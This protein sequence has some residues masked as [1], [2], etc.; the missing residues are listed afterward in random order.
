MSKDE[1]LKK[2]WNPIKRRIN[3][4]YTNKEKMLKYYPEIKKCLDLL[5]KEYFWCEEENYREIIFNIINDIKDEPKCQYCNNK[6]IFNGKYTNYC[7]EHNRVETNKKTIERCKG[8]KQ[9][10][11]TIEKRANSNRGQKR[12]EQARYNISLGQKNSPNYEIKCK[13]MKEIGSKPE[14]RK[15]RSERM[16]KAIEEGRFT[17][18]ITNTRTHFTTEINGK[19]FRSS[20]EGIFYLFFN[21]WQGFNYKFESLRIPYVD[22]KNKKRIYIVDFINYDTKE[23]IEIKPKCH[24]DDKDV[25][26]KEKALIIWAKEN[27]FIYKMLN[28]D[29][30]KSL[31]YKMIKENF[32]HNFLNEFKEKYRYK[33]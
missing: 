13:K 26:L 2:V 16:K 24:K 15:K 6:A 14:E 8:I 30:I 25:R 33:L 17:P 12:S 4:N 31:Y 28:E 21:I 20:F 7:K 23:V 5:K 1:L 18:C 9:S 27:D 32:N 19:K 3:P 22:S 29:D 10:K 11:K